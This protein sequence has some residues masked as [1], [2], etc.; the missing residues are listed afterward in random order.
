MAHNVSFTVPDRPLGKSDIIFT[1]KKDGKTLGNLHISR[2][3]L[4][5]FP[6]YTTYGYRMNWTKFDKIM[7]DYAVESEAR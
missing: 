1:V 2:G 5:W 3:S 6:S 7:K 4:V